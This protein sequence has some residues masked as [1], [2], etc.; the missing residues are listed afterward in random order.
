ML[1]WRVLLAQLLKVV[2]RLRWKPNITISTV[3][4]RHSLIWISML[5]RELQVL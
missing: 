4:L 3:E 5:F 2:Y 1:L